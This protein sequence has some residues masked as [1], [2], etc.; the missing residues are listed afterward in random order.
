MLL[1]SLKHQGEMFCSKCCHQQD[2]LGWYLNWKVAQ[3][4]KDIFRHP[5]AET[6]PIHCL[7][8][9]DTPSTWRWVG[10]RGL[11]AKNLSLLG[12]PMGQLE[13]QPLFLHSILV[14]FLR[15]MEQTGWLWAVNPI[16][17]FIGILE[18]YDRLYKTASWGWAL[19]VPT[20]LFG[21]KAAFCEKARSTHCLP[22]GNVII[23]FN[24][25]SF[26]L[27]LNSTLMLTSNSYSKKVETSYLIFLS[28]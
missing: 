3:Y 12:I 8:S 6:L 2:L 13:A 4:F 22:K 18:L 27:C 1:S 19:G 25:V 26:Q 5:D 23:S 10:V 7:Y 14:P 24:C 28:F 15:R 11:E 21:F 9:H 20:P 16:I 17:C